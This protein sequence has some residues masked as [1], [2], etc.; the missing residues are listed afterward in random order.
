MTE[1]NFNIPKSIQRVILYLCKED[2]T[3]FVELSPLI[4]PEYFEFPLHGEIFSYIKSHYRDYKVLPQDDIIRSEMEKVKTKTREGDKI[5]FEK[6]DV[7]DEIDLINAV[8]KEDLSQKEYLLDQVEKFAQE[9]EMKLAI[10]DSLGDLESGNLGKIQERVKNALR[11][12]RNVDLG[13]NY[14]TAYKKRW[15]DDLNVEYNNKIPS[16]LPTINKILDGGLVPGEAGLIAAPSGRGKSIAL[17]NQAVKSLLGRKKVLYI[18]LEMSE[19]KVAK[20]IDSMLTL[21]PQKLLSTNLGVAEERIVKVSDLVGDNSLRIKK[22]PSRQIT[23][24]DLA[25]L[26]EN[27]KLYENFEP[28]EIIID[29]LELVKSVDSDLPEYMAQERLGHEFRD[30]GEEYNATVWTA[31]QTNRESKDV[32]IITDKHFADSYGK[33]RGFDIGYSLNQTLEEKEKGIM[34]IFT[35]KVR[36]GASEQLIRCSIDYTTLVIKE[37]NIDESEEE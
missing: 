15:L 2:K 36:D 35:F 6:I 24:H 27:L 30:L 12:S 14:F 11:V 4:K 23:V 9:Q 29:Y 8:T 33:T 28:D 13:H 1:A 20:R 3:F 10:I 5:K 26:L 19:P 25:A 7:T 17:A 21:V 37:T 22:Y 31:T 32:P 18:S 16:F 34:R